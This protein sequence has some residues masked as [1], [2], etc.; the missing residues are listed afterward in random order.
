MAVTGWLENL[1]TAEKTAL[2]QDG[3]SRP[4]TSSLVL[5]PRVQPSAWLPPRRA[6][7][8]GT[9]EQEGPRLPD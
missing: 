1:R 9:A 5:S 8:P 2:L 6:S 7:E 3:N 4:P